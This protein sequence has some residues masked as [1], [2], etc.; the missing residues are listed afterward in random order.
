MERYG[1]SASG[2]N[3]AGGFERRSFR[4]A[5]EHGHLCF[6]CEGNGFEFAGGNGQREFCGLCYCAS[7]IYA[8]FFFVIVLYASVLIVVF[9]PSPFFFV[10]AYAAG[11]ARIVFSDYLVRFTWGNGDGVVQQHLECDGGNGS[12]LVVD[13]FRSTSC[14]FSDLCFNGSNLGYT[15]DERDISVYRDGGR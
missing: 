12:V 2:G 5:D 9:Y 3:N 7:G 4:D 15:D 10:Y 11:F 13:Y 8:S 1:W 6:Q 14:R